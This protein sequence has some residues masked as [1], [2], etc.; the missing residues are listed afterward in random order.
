MQYRTI[1][2]VVRDLEQRPAETK[3]H[4]YHPVPFPEFRHLT[5]STSREEAEAKMAAVEAA[6][7]Q[8]F[9]AGLQGRTIL[10]IGAN[11]GLHTFTL[12][13][14]GARVTAYEGHPRYGPI[15]AFLASERA[16]DVEWHGR[17]FTA[18]DLE[19]RHYDAA[20]M[21]SVFQWISGGDERL[22]E[23]KQLLRAV[24]RHADCLVFELGFNS[25]Q[26][27][28]TTPLRNQVR[29][30]DRLLRDATEYDRFTYLSSA[31]PWGG[32]RHLFIATRGPPE[33]RAPGQW[34]KHW[35]PW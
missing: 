24:S 17:F 18:D 32:A 33:V 8:R 5:T 35:P 13:A 1:Q 31:R 3:G 26:S 27:A 10:D 25:G 12:A 16:P 14:R 20:L 19:G 2:D 21:L 28:V 22:P 9:P 7:R 30:L 23:A 34:K 11:A 29:A 15:G 6:L 4:V